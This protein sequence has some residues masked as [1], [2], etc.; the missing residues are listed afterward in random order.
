MLS[1]SDGDSVTKTHYNSF[2]ANSNYLFTPKSSALNTVFYAL[3][4]Q[5][6]EYFYTHF[7]W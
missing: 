7:G 4:N 3:F 5:R 6:I 1:I 2:L